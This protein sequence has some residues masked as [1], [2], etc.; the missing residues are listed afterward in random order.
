MRDLPCTS[1][2]KLTAAQRA[3][4]IEE[5]SNFSCSRWVAQVV[6]WIEVDNSLFCP[7][8]LHRSLMVC[9]SLPLAL[10]EV[11]ILLRLTTSILYILLEEFLFSFAKES[12][13]AHCFTLQ[14]CTTNCIKTQ[15]H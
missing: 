10:W 8:S 3:L 4:G 6:T 7:P 14:G 2:P 15:T 12:I 11:R 9:H 13:Y 5:V 1:Q